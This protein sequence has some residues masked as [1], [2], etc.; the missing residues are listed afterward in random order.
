MS[1]NTKIPAGNIQTS[2]I[3]PLKIDWPEEQFHTD[4]QSLFNFKFYELGWCTPGNNKLKQT[5]YLVKESSY[6]LLG[7]SATFQNV[8]TP[9]KNQNFTCQL[10]HNP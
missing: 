6:T 7:M 5:E 9:Y 2:L 10:L 8:W 4:W 3:I 1:W